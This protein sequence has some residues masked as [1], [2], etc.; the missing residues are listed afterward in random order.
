M[1]EED[2]DDSVAGEEVRNDVDWGV[3]DPECT[4]GLGYGGAHCSK[5]AAQRGK[6][7][8]PPLGRRA[9]LAIHGHGHDYELEQRWIRRLVEDG[10]VEDAEGC[11][12]RGPRSTSF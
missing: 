4:C 7:Y 10:R 12:R 9:Y 3:A 6:Y 5:M 1:A 8:V 11:F 2:E